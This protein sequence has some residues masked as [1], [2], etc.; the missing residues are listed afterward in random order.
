MSTAKTLKPPEMI[1][2][3]LRSRMYRYPSSSNVQISQRLQHLRHRLYRTCKHRRFAHS[4]VDC[5]NA[6]IRRVVVNHFASATY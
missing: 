4:R 2:S 3:F 1:M 5:E 6:C